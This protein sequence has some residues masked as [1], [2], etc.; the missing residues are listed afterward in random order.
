MYMNLTCNTEHVKFMI[1]ITVLVG[2]FVSSILT[3]HT[4]IILMIMYMC[5]SAS[6]LNNTVNEMPCF[7]TV[8]KSAVHDPILDKE[9]SYIHVVQCTC[10]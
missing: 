9:V 6:T 4:Y 2:W 3:V 1:V 7:P 10:K 5:S 8:C